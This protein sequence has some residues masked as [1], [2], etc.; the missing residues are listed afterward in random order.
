V[1]KTQNF[2]IQDGGQTPYSKTSFLAV[3]QQLTNAMSNY[4]NSN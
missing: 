1:T 2:K 4:E 3:T